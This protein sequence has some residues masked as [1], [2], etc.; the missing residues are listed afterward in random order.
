MKLEDYSSR[1]GQ[2]LSEILIVIERKEWVR[3]PVFCDWVDKYNILVRNFNSEFSRQFAMFGVAEGH[4]SRS[5]KTITDIAVQSLKTSISELKNEV[6]R[7]IKETLDEGKRFNCFK[8]GKHT[9]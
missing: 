2:I 6:E 1:L 8:I 3:P 9:T 4:Y 7:K 5:G